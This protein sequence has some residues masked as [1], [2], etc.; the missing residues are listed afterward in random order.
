MMRQLLPEEVEELAALEA[1]LFPENCFNENTLRGELKVSQCWVINDENKI[2]GYML[3]RIDDQI[4]DILRLGV[5]SSHARQG[6]AS[7]LLTR[8]LQEA[9]KAMLMVKKG[10]VPALKLYLSFGFKVVAH[11]E[12]EDSWVMATSCD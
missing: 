7:R 4:I 6:I 12:H 10:N 2:L 5:R 1:E 11:T 3:A 9:P 8:A